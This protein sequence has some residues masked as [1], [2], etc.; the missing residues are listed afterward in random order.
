M[1][2]YK[3]FHIDMRDNYFA[4]FVK[5]NY[6]YLNIFLDLYKNKYFEF[7]IKIDNYYIML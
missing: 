3:Y 1:N 2:L 5:Y 4:N 7:L 6:I